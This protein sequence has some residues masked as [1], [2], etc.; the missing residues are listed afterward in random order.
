PVPQPGE[1]CSGR[2]FSS[3]RTPPAKPAKTAE[4]ARTTT[5]PL[6]ALIVDRV[7]GEHDREQEHVVHA[8]G[9]MNHELLPECELTRDRRHDLATEADRVVPAG[10]ASLRSEQAEC[11]VDV[12]MLAE[13]TSVPDLGDT[14]T[15][16][17]DV[18]RGGHQVLADLGDLVTCL[19]AEGQALGEAEVAADVETLIA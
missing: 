9:D 8:L 5:I 10:E 16:D 17:D 19:V 13:E 3:L 12:V 18:V 2:S 15:A 14:L 6:A 4:T 11:R 1:I 7:D